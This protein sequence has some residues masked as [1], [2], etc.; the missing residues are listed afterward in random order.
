CE[1]AGWTAA[2]MRQ[3]DGPEPEEPDEEPSELL[4]RSWPAAEAV[5]Q[6]WPAVELGAGDEAVLGGEAAVDA[7]GAVDAVEAPEPMAEA[8]PAA[9]ATGPHQPSE[10][11]PVSVGAVIHEFVRRASE[12]QYAAP[13]LPSELAIPEPPEPEYVEEIPSMLPATDIT[14]VEEIIRLR[15]ELR[16]AHRTIDRLRHVNRKLREALDFE[17]E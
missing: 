6:A 16:E 3:P 4:A 12:P 9:P 7:M 1:A 13:P 10:P 8:E 2:M 15:Y 11:E 17:A 5:A 14:A